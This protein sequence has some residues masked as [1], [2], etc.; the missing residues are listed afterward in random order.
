MKPDVALEQLEAVAAQL[1]VKV[2]YERLAVGMRGG[3]CR[4]KTQDSRTGALSWRVIVD[5]RATVE[6][7][8]TTLA[9]AL[10]GFDVSALELAP[11]LRELLRLHEP[12]S[13]HRRTAA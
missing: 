3:L 8:V 10:A 7:R 9:T 2:S 5:K 13:K 11:K 12:S 4:L 1:D 6:D